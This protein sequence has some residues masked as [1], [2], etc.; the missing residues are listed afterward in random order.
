VGGLTHDHGVQTASPDVSPAVVHAPVGAF[1]LAV[2]PGLMGRS[3]SAAQAFTRG[4]SLWTHS[5]LYI[6]S[7]HVVQ[8]E[9]GGVQIRR[10]PHRPSTGEPVLWS[11]APIQRHL[12][13]APHITARYEA[14]LRKRVADAALQLVD[15][16]Y[17]WLDYV[18]IAGAEW[19]V[20]GWQRLRSRVD[21]KGQFLCSS[22]VDRAYERAGVHLFSDQRPAGQ[23]TPA[24]LARYDEA[25][26]RERLSDL[27]QR[28]TDIEERLS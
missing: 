8:A 21:G 26:V 5:G 15:S 11:D 13:D 14:Q 18:A 9:P 28:I 23:V 4:G 17:A 16:P 7:G 10:F 24:D 1:F 12:A 19:K 22:L 27:E 25:W 3:V 2:I 20:P 6:G